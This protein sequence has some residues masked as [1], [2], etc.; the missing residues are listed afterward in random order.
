MEEVKQKYLPQEMLE[1]I[2]EES[3]ESDQTMKS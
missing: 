1:E 2:N 3:V